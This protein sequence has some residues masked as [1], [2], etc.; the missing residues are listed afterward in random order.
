MPF[1]LVILLS[2]LIREKPQ[3]LA[4]YR[5]SASELK[6][7]MRILKASRAKIIKSKACTK[8][9][10]EIPRPETYLRYASEYT[11][12]PKLK[13]T[14]ASNSITILKVVIS[15]SSEEVLKIT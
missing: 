11:L 10:K 4:G 14:L 15:E 3:S 8:V 9:N 7:I 1:L 12:F 2:L 13:Y 6:I 5:L